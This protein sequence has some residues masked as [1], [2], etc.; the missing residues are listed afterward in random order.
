MFSIADEVEQLTREMQQAETAG[1]I[2]KAVKLRMNIIQIRKADPFLCAEDKL[3]E[4]IWER[5]E[6]RIERITEE[7]ARLQARAATEAESNSNSSKLSSG[8]RGSFLD[9]L[10]FL[11]NDTTDSNDEEGTLI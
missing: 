7:I 9:T 3:Q 4:A 5:D 8:Y 6:T 2:I 10:G 11:D 1:N